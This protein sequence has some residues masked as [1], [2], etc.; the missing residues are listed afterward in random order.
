MGTLGDELIGAL[1]QLLFRQEFQGF[2]DE[3]MQEESP[4]TAFRN[5]AGA[6]VEECIFIQGSR[7]GAMGA[8][9]VVGVDL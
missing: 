4:C 1:A 3:S 6:Q 9:H 8:A 2:V 7:G 5:P